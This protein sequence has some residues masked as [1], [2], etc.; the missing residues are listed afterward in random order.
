MTVVTGGTDV[1]VWSIRK[2]VTFPGSFFSQM[3]GRHDES[4]VILWK[5][6]RKRFC[7]VDE[8]TE[9]ER[10]EYI[11]IIVTSYVGNTLDLMFCEGR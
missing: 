11:I 1:C 6:D 7:E 8:G 3:Q 5:C 4:Q 2:R 10:V 9:G